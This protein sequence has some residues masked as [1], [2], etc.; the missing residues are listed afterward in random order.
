MTNVTFA[1]RPE[2]EMRPSPEKP[3]RVAVEVSGPGGTK[4]GNMAG[5]SAVMQHLFARMRYTAPHFRLA[6]VEGE[7]GVGKTLAAHTLHRL[8]PAMPGRLLHGWLRSF[9]SDRPISGGKRA[10]ACC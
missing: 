9:W 4:L 8:G 3:L 7:P 1:I 10:A 6:A 2:Y 5:R